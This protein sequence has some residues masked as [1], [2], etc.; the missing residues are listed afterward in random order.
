[1]PERKINTET[2]LAIG[3]TFLGGIIIIFLVKWFLLFIIR[4]WA[5]TLLVVLAVLGVAVYSVL[6]NTK[7]PS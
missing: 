6:Q 1:M 4:H 3:L 2:I 7:T 5:L